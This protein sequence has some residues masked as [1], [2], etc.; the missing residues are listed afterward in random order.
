M[1]AWAVEILLMAIPG[2][3]GEAPFVPDV[4]L[5]AAVAVVGYREMRWN[6]QQQLRGAFRKLAPEHN[7]LGT[8]G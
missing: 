8:R 4:G 5:V 3:V 7:D 2:D 1:N 6:P